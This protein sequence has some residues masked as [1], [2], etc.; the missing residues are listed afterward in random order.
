MAILLIAS[1]A[2]AGD[3]T[4]DNAFYW[5]HIQLQCLHA[6]ACEPWGTEKFRHICGICGN[7]MIRND[8]SGVIKPES[9]HAV[10]NCALFR[11]ICSQNLIKCRNTIGADHNQAVS[12]IIQFTNFTFLIWFIF[13][14]VD[15]SRYILICLI[16]SEVFRP[17]H[18][19]PWPY[20]PDTSCT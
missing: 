2:A 1:P 19:W 7:H 13:F 14:H 12:Q 3:I 6:A 20:L 17:F 11:N 4:T 9:G 18:K 8:V 16:L 5:N 10:Q 15:S